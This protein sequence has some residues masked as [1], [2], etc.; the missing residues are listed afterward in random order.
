MEKYK[1][2]TQSRQF[3]STWAQMRDAP[4]QAH[5]EHLSSTTPVR[6][7]VNNLILLHLI[8]PRPPI[9]HSQTWISLMDNKVLGSHAG[10]RVRIRFSNYSRLFSCNLTETDRSRRSGSET[11]VFV[12]SRSCLG[13]IVVRV[14]PTW[15]PQRDLRCHPEVS[16]M[17][18]QSNDLILHGARKRRN[19]SIVN[20]MNHS[21]KFSRSLIC[22]ILSI[23]IHSLLLCWTSHITG[24]KLGKRYQFPL[25]RHKEL[26]IFFS[27]LKSEA[28]GRSQGRSVSWQD[29]EGGLPVTPKLQMLLPLMYERRR[30]GHGERADSRPWNMFSLTRRVFLPFP[31]SR[32]TW[33]RTNDGP[34]PNT[35]VRG[36]KQLLTAAIHLAWKCEYV[37]LMPPPLLTPL[38]SGGL[39]WLQLLNL[40]DNE[41]WKFRLAKA[42]ADCLLNIIYNQAFKD[43][44]VPRPPLQMAILGSLQKWSD[45]G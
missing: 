36:R 40:Q 29:V 43:R 44:W 38:Q 5:A 13:S 15:S 6:K 14:S 20:S 7:Q 41:L 22:C 30:P 23:V 34:N 26:A 27:P 42:S 33:Q 21:K 32:Q 37:W 25:W 12:N 10:A 4:R 35:S 2:L 31:T 9:H 16:S 24:N 18:C 39:I 11:L 28:S 19:T 1:V 17:A 3:D 8:S 45:R